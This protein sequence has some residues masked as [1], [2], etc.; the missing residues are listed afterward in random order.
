MKHAV[1]RKKE[2]D[3]NGEKRYKDSGNRIILR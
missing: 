2:E 3:E 1:N